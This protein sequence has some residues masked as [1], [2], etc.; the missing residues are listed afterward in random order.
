VRALALD[1]T[2]E[3]QARH[4][5]NTA[6]ETFGGLDVLVNNAGC[7]KA[8]LPYFRERRAGHIIQI[9]SIAGRVGPIGRAPYASAKFGVEGFSESLPKEVGTSGLKGDD[10]RVWRLPHRFCGHLHGLS[11][12]PPRVQCYGRRYGALPAKL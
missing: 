7:G 12:R 2:N 4:A 11:R 9:T 3:A 6:V 1:V 5:I 8:A 10:R